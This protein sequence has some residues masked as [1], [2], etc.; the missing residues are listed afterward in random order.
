[1]LYEAGEVREH[2]RKANSSCDA[3][4]LFLVSDYLFAQNLLPSSSWMWCMEGPL[5]WTSE[6]HRGLEKR[7]GL[8]R[9]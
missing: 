7:V 5:S 6:D 3:S 2:K 4:H 8:E 1:M 9:P